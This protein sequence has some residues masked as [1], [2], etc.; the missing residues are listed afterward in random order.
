MA[1]KS[2]MREYWAARS[3]LGK[4]VGKC[5]KSE[6]P[7]HLNIIWF[8][9]L[10]NVGTFK[11]SGWVAPGVRL[12]N[13]TTDVRRIFSQSWRQKS[14]RRYWLRSPELKKSDQRTSSKI[15]HGVEAQEHLQGIFSNSKGFPPSHKITMDQHVEQDWHSNWSNSEHSNHSQGMDRCALYVRLQDY[16]RIPTP[17]KILEQDVSKDMEFIILPWRPTVQAVVSNLKTLRFRHS[18]R[19]VDGLIIRQNVLHNGPIDT[20]RVIGPASA[21]R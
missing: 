6:R 3:N 11:S 20:L 17:L 9:H 8:C 13:S 18:P 7:S 10:I 15:W 16:P 19:M 12:A 4:W 1:R 14:A 21:T 5:T 2:S